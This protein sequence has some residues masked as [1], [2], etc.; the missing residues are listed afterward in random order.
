M[1]IV[2]VVLEKPTP[3]SELGTKTAWDRS[4]KIGH[5]ARERRKKDT[6]EKAVVATSED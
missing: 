6:K 1:Q 2:S 3:K 4:F 5:A